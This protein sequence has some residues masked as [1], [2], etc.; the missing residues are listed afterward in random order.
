MPTM[1]FLMTED[2]AAS[3]LGGIS[4]RTLQRWRMTGEG[5]DFTKI[6]RLVRYRAT[7]LDTFLDNR[8]RTSTSEVG[9]D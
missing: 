9:H 8:V 1:P 2:A 3:Y 7:D 4:T 6:G 5:P